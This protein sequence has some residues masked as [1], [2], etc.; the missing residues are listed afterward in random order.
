[1]T[2]LARFGLFL[3]GFGLCSAIIP[4][5]EPAPQLPG[6]KRVT[7]PA[8]KT[9]IKDLLGSL[10]KQSGVKVEARLLD[11]DSLLATAV[12]E[13]SFWD[14]LDA[15]AREAGARVDLSARKGQIQLVPL[16]GPSNSL[17]CGDGPFR[18]SVEKIATARDFAT[19]QGNCT[20]TLEVAWVPELLPLFVES[21]PQGLRILEK[22]GKVLPLTHE[23]STLAP[24][25]G[26]GDGRLT[27]RTEVN[28]PAPS[29][30][31]ETLALVEGKLSAVVP[32]KML[33]Y[34]FA[35]LDRLQKEGQS[36]QQEGVTCRVERVILARDRWTV[37]LS[38][39]YP[40]GSNRSL[41]S[42]QSWVVNN[43]LLLVSADGKTRL[44]VSSYVLE[45]ASSQRATLSYNFKDLPGTARGKPADWRLSYLTPARI[46]EVPFAF[47][48][49]DVPLP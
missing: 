12:K 32:S 31:V 25:G 11:R 2:A 35:T 30:K 18:I 36:L 41:E 29:R 38:L 6:S 9:S 28:I 43:E 19:G 40:P 21:Q 7:L 46:I 13:A 44:P 16:T 4:A 47:S 17:V 15:I 1:M 45:G 48:F 49:K 3:L 26:E 23:G 39:A 42:Y 33:T 24:V 10:Q 27:F 20:L 37:R 34:H 8:E 5:E 14:A 22:G